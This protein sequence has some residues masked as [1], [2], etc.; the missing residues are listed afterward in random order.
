MT[1]PTDPEA[2]RADAARHRA[3]LADTVEELAART[4][5][6]ARVR[7]GAAAVAEQA[8]DAVSTATD[9][10]KQAVSTALGEVKDAGRAV[11]DQFSGPP[12]AVARR[13]VPWVLVAVVV[14]G[15]VV[16]WWAWRRRS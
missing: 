4:N 8:K 7:K 12:S 6:T 14:A 3:E 1:E 13:P 10:A 11:T 5:V 15:A 9:E 2:L 16:G